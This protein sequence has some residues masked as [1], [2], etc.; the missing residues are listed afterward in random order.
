MPYTALSRSPNVTLPEGTLDVRGWEVRSAQDSEKVGKVD[1]II[2]SGGEPRYLD[3]DLGG[4]FNTK[5]VLLP[6]GWA[7][8]DEREDVIWVPTMTKEQFKQ[9]PEYRS[10]LSALT[11]DYEAEIRRAGPSTLPGGQHY[12][13]ERFYGPRTRTLTGAEREAR[14]TRS[15]EELAIGKRAVQAGEAAIRKTVETERVRESVPVTREEVTVERRPVEPGM[16]AGDVEIGEDQIRV[17]IVEEEVTVEKRVVPKE[18]VVIRKEAV[19][20]E[21]VVEDTVR[22]ERI[23]VDQQGKSTTGSRGR[24]TRSRQQRDDEERKR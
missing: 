23:D 6:V 13:H 7:Q 2:L 11:E 3:V 20:E 21:R 17:P 9:L 22:K 10:N 1:D 14:V 4:L 5:H 18:E 24:R 15:E 8:V 16:A 12:S 19:Q